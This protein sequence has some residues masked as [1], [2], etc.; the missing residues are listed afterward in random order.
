[1]NQIERERQA[2]VDLYKQCGGPEWKHNDNWLSSHPV[3][4]WYGVGT[5]SNGFVWRVELVK[6]NL[7]GRLPSSIG[8][9]DYVQIFFLMDNNLSGSLP[10]SIGDWTCI[11]QVSFKGNK[12]TGSLPESIARWYPWYVSVADNR[13][14]GVVPTGVDN[15]LFC[16][17][18]LREELAL[19]L[20]WRRIDILREEVMSIS[21]S[22]L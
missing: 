8:H 19:M 2:L 22:E 12:L 13:L 20:V 16:W 3:G 21:L 6:N 1:M 17:K 5:N 15:E 10:V 11:Q 14:T 9:L 4:E 18:I 7:T